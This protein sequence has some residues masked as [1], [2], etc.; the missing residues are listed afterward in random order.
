M[1]ENNQVIIA[2]VSHL[3]T[4]FDYSMAELAQLVAANNLKVVDQIRQ[5]ID[6]INNKTYFG[7]GKVQKIKQLAQYHNVS[8]IIVNDELSP[9]QVRNLEKATQLHFLD[10]T[11]LILQVFAQRAHSRQ[12]QLQVAIAQL[13]YQLPRIHPSGNPL[14][15]QRGQSGLANRGAGESKLELNRRTIRQQITKLKQE[16]RH[17]EQ[18]LNTQGARRQNSKLPQVALVGYTNAGKSTTLNGILDL[19]ADKNSKKVFV[20]DQLFATL[21]TSIRKITLPQKPSFLLSDTVG[22]VSKLPHNLI[23][24]FQ[25]TL[26]EAKNADLLVQVIDASDSHREQMMQTTQQTLSEIGITNKP[27]IYAYNKADQTL[28]FQGPQV[29]GNNIYY[30]ALQESSL[31]T[32]IELIYQKLFSNYRVIKVLIPYSNSQLNQ[33]INQLVIQNQSYTNEGTIYQLLVSPTDY[34]SL[35]EYQID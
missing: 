14:D 34:E 6:Q 24:A 17:V 23:E 29:I 12:A 33:S 25:S 16:L 13:Q 1:E 10:R 32:L 11:E 35:T 8:L 21:D 3:Q 27:M 4:D 15:Q 2:G 20:K 30:S 22:F 18:T 5:H 7:S 31:K 26:A 28:D 9:A 19:V